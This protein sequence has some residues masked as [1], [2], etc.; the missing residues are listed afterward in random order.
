[1]PFF[2]TDSVAVDAV[3]SRPRDGDC[4]EGQSDL[5]GVTDLTPAISL[6]EMHGGRDSHGEEDGER[7][8]AGLEAEDDQDRT[9]GLGEHGGGAK[10]R[11]TLC[12]PHVLD[13]RAELGPEVRP[14]HELGDSV[15]KHHSA[16]AYPKQEQGEVHIF[17]SSQHGLGLTSARVAVSLAAK[18][19]VARSLVIYYGQPWKTARMKRFYAQ[20]VSPDDLCIDVGAHVGNRVRAWRS[21]G[22]RVVAIEPQPRMVDML[23][24]LFGADTRVDILPIGLS[25][26]AGELTLHVNTRNP[27]ITSF[28]SDWVD[29]FSRIESSP[30]DEEIGVAVTTLDE[31][32]EQFGMPG[33]CKIDVEGFE[34]KVMA[35]LSVPIPV[36]SFEAFPLEVDRS[37]ACVDRLM[38]LGP[39][40]FRTV[41]AE[42]FRWVESD[43]IDAEGIRAR[44]RSWTMDEGSG[45]VY[46]RL[47]SM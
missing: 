43:W 3:L 20:F 24:H 18:W 34:D 38:E 45:D 17:E 41:R 1:M 28:S 12:D 42:Q 30:F 37:L 44:L 35:G 25:D 4:E 31:V 10:Q 29:A 23:Q 2:C 19:G 33:F 16:E 11:V 32:V 7:S 40:R 46:A 14:S 15:G 39:Y 9:H 36:L 13:S 5:D 26:A 21:L 27:T 47:H 22:A 6:S 8:G